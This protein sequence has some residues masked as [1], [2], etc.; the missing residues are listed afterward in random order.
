MPFER[1]FREEL[2]DYVLEEL[3]DQALNSIPCID[4]DKVKFMI[5]QHMDGSWNRYPLIWKLLVLKQWLDKNK[6]GL[7]IK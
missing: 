4:V 5:N 6:A 7:M 3:N 2:K 1:W